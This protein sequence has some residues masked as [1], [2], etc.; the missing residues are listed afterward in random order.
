MKTKKKIEM[1]DGYKNRKFTLCM[2]IDNAP[3]QYPGIVIESYGTLCLVREEKAYTEGR[4]DHYGIYRV[5]KNSKDEETLSDLMIDYGK[6]DD[7]FPVYGAPEL[8]VRAK[9]ADIVA[10]KKLKESEDQLRTE[11][12]VLEQK[13]KRKTEELRTINSGF[14][15]LKLSEANIE[16]KELTEGQLVSELFVTDKKVRNLAIDIVVLEKLKLTI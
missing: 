12:L 6:D 15:N 9:F 5:V 3:F 2:N 16:L 8:E 4:F 11:R 1:V 10:Q 14:I 7:V 13:E